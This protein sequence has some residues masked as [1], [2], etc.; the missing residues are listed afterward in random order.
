MV[1]NESNTNLLAEV[2]LTTQVAWP[3]EKWPAGLGEHEL[4]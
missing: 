2:I 3:P 1:K 4:N